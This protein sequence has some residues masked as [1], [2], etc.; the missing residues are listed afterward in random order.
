MAKIF[1]FSFLLAL[2]YTA[3]ITQTTVEFHPVKDNSMFSE[4]NA[5]SNGAGIEFFVGRTGTHAGL[6]N[7]RALLQ[8]E[9]ASIPA[10]SVIESASLSVTCTKA[11]PAGSRAPN[12]IQLRKCMATWGEGGSISNGGAGATATAGDAT[13][14]CRFASG[15]GS[16]SQ[17]W[18]TTGG[19]FSPVISSTVTV[20]DI[21]L[22]TFPG[23]PSLVADI[24]A[25]I[26]APAVNFGWV[27]TGDEITP[28]STRA[29]HSKEGSLVAT[30]LTITYSPAL[31]TTNTWTGEISSA[32]E[33]PGNWSCGKVPDNT[34][35]VIINS[36]TVILNSNATV[37]SLLL[38]PGVSFT[39]NQEFVLTV[40]N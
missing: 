8:F 7:R 40:I 25:W 18:A 35:D 31:C 26:D 20:N 37:K 6:V 12:P 32:W 19:D 5:A 9:L 23:S 29:F 14:T 21:G 10:G 39:V 2:V 22:Y 36:G 27:L 33:T 30:T 34:M 15:S 24:Q 4:N 13:W 1:L 28:F 16:C 11:P 17:A 3:G 38:S